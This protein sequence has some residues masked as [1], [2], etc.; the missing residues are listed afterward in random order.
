MNIIKIHDDLWKSSTATNFFAFGDISE[1]WKFAKVTEVSK[2]FDKANGLT[3][4][5]T[6]VLNG[7]IIKLNENELIVF[8]YFN[9]RRNFNISDE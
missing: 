3:S 4:G 5:T 8:P 1:I 7:D 2:R 6:R 9:R